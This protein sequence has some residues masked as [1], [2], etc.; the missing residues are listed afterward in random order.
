MTPE[1]ED[2]PDNATL[3]LALLEVAG[4]EDLDDDAKEEAMDEVLIQMEHG[5]D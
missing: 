4:N 2:A 1:A 5:E 3:L